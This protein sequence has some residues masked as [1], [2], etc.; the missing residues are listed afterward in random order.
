MKQ[1]DKNRKKDS[2]K[3][4]NINNENQKKLYQN[5]SNNDDTEKEKPIH[6]KIEYDQ[7]KNIENK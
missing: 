7:N 6:F 5:Y 1:N 4:N 2:E 3:D